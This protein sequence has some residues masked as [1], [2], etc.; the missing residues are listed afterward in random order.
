MKLVFPVA[1][2]LL[3]NEGSIVCLVKPQFEA[4][5]SQVGK[6]G[7]VRDEKVHEEVISNVI[8]YG[9]ASGMYKHGITCSPIKGAKGN[10]EFLMLFKKQNFSKISCQ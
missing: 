7:I 2:L 6:K 10:V 3:K 8:E 5:R 4:G 1:A 9:Q